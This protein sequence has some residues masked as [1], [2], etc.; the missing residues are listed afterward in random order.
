[1][2]VISSIQY[3]FLSIDDDILILTTEECSV[4]G[5]VGDIST[6]EDFAGG[7][8]RRLGREVEHLELNY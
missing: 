1:M 5:G 3:I 7:E 6:A 2:L 8:L 4:G